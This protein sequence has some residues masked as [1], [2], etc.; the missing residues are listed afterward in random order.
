MSNKLSYMTKCIE[1]V[2]ILRKDVAEGQLAFYQVDK[3]PPGLLP[4]SLADKCT[5]AVVAVSG[6]G[7][8]SYVAI[9]PERLDVV[10]NVKVH[11]NDPIIYAANPNAGQTFPTGAFVHHSNYPG[12]TEPVTGY[13]TCSYKQTIT[14]IKADLITGLQPLGAAEPKYI[15]AISHGIDQFKQ[16][17]GQAF[18]EWSAKKV[19]AERPDI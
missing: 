6:N 7:T 2:E 12:R 18:E 11:D 5:S 1:S 19:V 9:I 4:Q 16:H 10:N 15:A 8:S 14:A 17:L 3:L 13:E